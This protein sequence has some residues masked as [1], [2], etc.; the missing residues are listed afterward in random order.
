MRFDVAEYVTHELARLIAIPSVTGSEMSCIVYLEHLLA[1]L[2]L[3]PLRQQVDARRANLIVPAKKRP[4]LLLTAHVDTV[5]DYGQPDLFTPHIEDGWIRGRGAA[6]VK[7]GI[8]AL[9]AAIRLALHES[10][11]MDH[12]ALAFTVDEEV[13]GTGSE[14]LARIVEADGAIVLEP[15]RLRICVAGAGS[16]EVEFVVSGFACHGSEFEQGTNAIEKAVNLVQHLQRA[17]R[18]QRFHPL[19]GQVGFN[20]MHMVGGSNALVVPDE[21]RVR[22]D[23]RFFPRDDSEEILSSLQHLAVVEDARV[24]IHDVSEPFETPPDSPV[25][26]LMEQ[27]LNVTSGHSAEHAGIKS[28]T[29]AEPLARRG[30][31]V[32]VFGPGDLAVAHTPRERIHVDEV[33]TAARALRQAMEL[34]PT[35]LGAPS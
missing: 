27:A 31:P 1:E 5:P 34:A 12:I 7:G 24:V 29:D 2:G 35:V 13:G 16:I 30:I 28:W 26:R 15:T 25:V 23:V 14:A 18:R 9:L 22:V 3:E 8:A 10:Q 33:V 4:A 32:V 20:L 17:L 11:S 6:D 19:L 21:C